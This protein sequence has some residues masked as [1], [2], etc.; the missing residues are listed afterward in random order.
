VSPFTPN[1]E[2]DWEIAAT[3]TSAGTTDLIQVRLVQSGNNATGSGAVLYSE[4]NS[5]VNLGGSCPAGNGQ[6][7]VALAFADFGP[8]LQSTFNEG[9]SI[10]TGN[11]QSDGKTMAGTYA[12]SPGSGCQDAGNW[13]ATKTVVLNANFSGSPNP[14]LVVQLQ[15]TESVS[16]HSVSLKGSLS[17]AITAT[18]SMTGSYVG[19]AIS[20]Q[21]TVN[22]PNQQPL[23]KPINVYYSPS[24]KAIYGCKHSVVRVF[25]RVPQECLEP[26]ST[27]ERFSTRS[28]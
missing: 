8:S 6:N 7:S 27:I 4:Q 21:L 22:I 13:T 11:G 28:S 23:T 17:G 3:S 18:I 16:S 1:A 15:I 26:V 25:R 20:G 10:F 14:G 9:G 2:G 5:N 19:N 12:A 24:Q